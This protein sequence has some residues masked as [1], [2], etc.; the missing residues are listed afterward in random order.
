V[1]GSPPG[2]M[3]TLVALGRR[4]VDRWEMWRPSIDAL[5]GESVYPLFAELVQRMRIALA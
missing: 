3:G 2:L 1:N 4:L 5:G